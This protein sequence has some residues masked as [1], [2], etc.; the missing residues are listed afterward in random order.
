[1]K[2]VSIRYILCLWT[3]LNCLCGCTDDTSEYAPEE[4]RLAVQLGGVIGSD[5]GSRATDEGFCDGDRMG[6]YVV[7]QVPWSWRTTV[8]RM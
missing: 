1:M 5:S 2:N 4:N 6:I 7:A 3:V 8:P